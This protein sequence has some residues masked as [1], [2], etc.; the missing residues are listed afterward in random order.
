MKQLLPLVLLS[1]TS[2]GISH[3]GRPATPPPAEVSVFAITEKQDVVFTPAGW[4]QSLVADLYLPSG[5]GPWP[6]VLLVHGGGWREPERRSD[7][8]GIARRLAKRG[9]VVMNAT[10][11]LVPHHRYPAAVK[12]LQLAHSWM[13]RHAASLHLRAD[14]IAIFG[15]SAGGHLAAL[16][17]GLDAPPSRRFQAVVAGGAPSDMRK[18]VGEGMASEFLGGTREEVPG[19]FAEASPIIH[20]TRDDPPVFL[21]HGEKDTTVPPDHAVDYQAALNRAGVPTELFWLKGRGHVAAFL[22]DEAAITAAIEF[23]DRHLR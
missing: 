8:A 6:G 13:E 19:P 18:F 4:S 10:Y 14:R 20:V 16:L 2:C 15:Y 21:Y 5:E 17:G 22:T 11:R 7:M 9:Y 23:L 3:L 1:L 12:D